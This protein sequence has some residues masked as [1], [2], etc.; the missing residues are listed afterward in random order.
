M[1]RQINT[2]D[3]K[4]KASL[5]S[6]VVVAF[7]LISL[8]V[9]CIVLGGYFYF[10][11]ISFFFLIAV[12]EMIHATGKKYAWYVYLLTYVLD[13]SYFIWFVIKGNVASYLAFKNGNISSWSFS[14]EPEFLGLSVSIY[15]II[16]SF[17]SYC[18]IGIFH[19]E[20]DL[21]DIMYLFGMSLFLGIGFQSLLF[22]RYYPFP[23][24]SKAGLDTSSPYF[25]YWGSAT[26]FL[27]VG[28]TTIMNDTWAYFVGIFF[29]KHHMNER[30]S[31]NKTW[32]GFYGGWILG[33]L[34]GLT[35]ALLCDCYG[36]P[37]LPSLAIFSYS[38]S[39]WWIVLL[40]LTIP[41]IAN[42]GDFTFSLIKRHF[43]FKDYGT[44][45]KA[46][47]GVLD[48]ADSLT[49]T[50]IFTSLIVIFVSNGWNI[51]A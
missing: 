43:G 36:Y 30:V 1:N 24:F 39:W 34:S 8:A 37:V 32:E 21:N 25:W 31:P 48:R 44:I 7:V 27:F 4:K 12:F 41:L 50:F 33:A 18:L 16:F 10:A 26:L 29:G 46:H 35:L 20:F 15:M 9:P 6:R 45:F 14:L 5:L 2:L 47:G 42:L 11:F 23:C 17:F 3:G 13:I 49:F 51:F 22:I 38:K 28:F 19:K 40:S